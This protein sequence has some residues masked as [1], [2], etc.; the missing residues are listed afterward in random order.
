M[1]IQVTINQ[2]LALA[3]NTRSN[4]QKAFDNGQI[5]LDK[6]EI[7]DTALRVDHFMAQM[8]Q[9][10][11]G[12]AFYYENLNYS[13]NRLSV[14][15]PREFKPNSSLDPLDYANNPQ[16]LANLVYG[17][18]MGNTGPNDGYTYRGHGLLQLT[19][20]DSYQQVTDTLQNDYPEAP[21]FVS[22]PDE[23]ISPEWSLA[24]AAAVWHWKKCNVPADNDDINGV[25]RAINGGLNGLSQR[26]ERLMQTKAIWKQP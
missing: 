7:S 10:S 5:Y 15:F 25:T 6:Y 1:A 16:K 12:F 3:P 24:V 22:F 26:V 14:V 9:E 21:N 13:A 23:V 18:Q 4:Y 20:K 17:G 8:L 19:G 2:V 11:C